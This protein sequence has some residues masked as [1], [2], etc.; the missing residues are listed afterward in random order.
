MGRIL[1]RLNFFGNNLGMLCHPIC[2][3][4]Y[5]PKSTSCWRMSRWSC[6]LLT[7]ALGDVW[8]WIC[9]YNYV[10]AC[11]RTY[12]Y[13]Y[14]W[15]YKYTHIIYIFACMYIYVCTMFSKASAV[16]CLRMCLRQSVA[17]CCSML[18]CGML[19]FTTWMRLGAPQGR[20]PSGG[21][22]P[23]T[24]FAL[25]DLD[26]SRNWFV[27]SFHLICRLKTTWSVVL[28]LLDLMH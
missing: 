15:V 3:R 10:Y 28:V 18:Q 4:L 2:I 21:I 26:L 1:V 13:L 12:P 11:I 25:G 16:Q 14:T 24:N 8:C 5:I 19:Q 20:K 23:C 22:H 9:A 17:V 27:V 7:C 6:E